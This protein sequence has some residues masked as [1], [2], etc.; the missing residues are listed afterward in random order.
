[1]KFDLCMISCSRSNVNKKNGSLH[2]IVLVEKKFRGRQSARQ[3]SPV[4]KR[5]LNI[6]AII[7]S[8]Q[9][10]QPLQRIPVVS[11]IKRSFQGKAAGNWEV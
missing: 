6:E 9:M 3:E 2:D 1:M 4:L 8:I 11:A 10:Q 5:S 7:V